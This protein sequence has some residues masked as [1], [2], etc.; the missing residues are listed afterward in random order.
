MLH[1]IGA[2]RFFRCRGHVQRPCS[3]SAVP[4]SG[5]CHARTCAGVCCYCTWKEGNQVPSCQSTLVQPHTCI[6]GS[7][8]TWRATQPSAVRMPAWRT[9]R[10]S[11]TCYSNLYLD[12]NHPT[13]WAN[14][15]A[16]LRHARPGQAGDQS[17]RLRQVIALTLESTMSVRQPHTALHLD[18]V[19]TTLSSNRKT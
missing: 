2:R 3:A 18:Q 17:V 15:V 13:A 4:V 5:L 12:H 8:H 14:N 11:R 1:T 10:P 7:S 6:L 9:H 19:R 16:A